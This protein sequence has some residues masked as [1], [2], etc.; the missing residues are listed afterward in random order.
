MKFNYDEISRL[1]M[2][3]ENPQNNI[4]KI[5]SSWISFQL[6]KVNFALK[7]IQF[8]GADLRFRQKKSFP[9][10]EIGKW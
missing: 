2:E 6:K 8:P 1:K 3:D 4:S 5:L 7:W 9:F 10:G